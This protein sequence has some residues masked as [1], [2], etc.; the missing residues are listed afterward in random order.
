[1]YSFEIKLYIVNEK[2]DKKLNIVE[3]VFNRSYCGLRLDILKAFE[4][5]ETL[6]KEYYE[7]FQEINEVYWS[8]DNDAYGCFWERNKGFVYKTNLKISD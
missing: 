6:V 8:V 3:E 7:L 2:D 5:L 1:M 4:S